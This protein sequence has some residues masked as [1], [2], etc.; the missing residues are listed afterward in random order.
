MSQPNDSIDPRLRELLQRLDAVPPRDAQAAERGR[1]TFLAQA[2]SL[3]RTTPARSATNRGWRIALLPGRGGFTFA[4][5]LGNLV[6]ALGLV[7]AVSSA[8]VYA[9]QDALPTNLLYSVKTLSEDIRL[10]LAATPE[11]RAGLALD[12]ANRRIDELTALSETGAPLPDSVMA[13]L[14]VEI[15]IALQSGIARDNP[16]L[17]NEINHTLDRLEQQLQVIDNAAA[18]KSSTNLAHVQKLFT[19]LRD[20]M[21]AWEGKILPTPTSPTS[22]ITTPIPSTTPIPPAT[23]IPST[24]TATPQPP[25]AATV[26]PP[27]HPTDWQTTWATIPATATVS[28]CFYF[29]PGV[30]ISSLPFSTTIPLCP[31]PT[32][33]PTPPANGTPFPLPSAWLTPPTNGTPFPLPPGWPTFPA[34]PTMPPIPSNWT[35]LPI[36]IVPP[37][38]TPPPLPLPK[39]TPPAQPP[40]KSTPPAPPPNWKPPAPPPGWTP[41]R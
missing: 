26:T 27:F 32:N 25:P 14:Q 2:E 13:R 11:A 31:W 37:N 7:L 18:S 23:T 22:P 19:T 3:R 6:I 35:P 8:T 1:V 30:S 28:A 33:W 21:Q 12:F 34:F 24:V 41:W 15:E 16:F 39:G 5:A 9:S 20:Q 36:T 40:P 4:S 17:A 38:W 29:P 10:D